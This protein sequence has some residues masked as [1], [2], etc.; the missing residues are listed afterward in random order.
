MKACKRKK[1]SGHLV[2]L[3]LPIV[4]MINFWKGE[5]NQMQ[6]VSS[7]SRGCT[8]KYFGSLLGHAFVAILLENLWERH[9]LRN[10]EVH[11]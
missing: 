6:Y 11:V 3:R 1:D 9:A 4:V 5:C 10:S 7:V 2:Q 8:D